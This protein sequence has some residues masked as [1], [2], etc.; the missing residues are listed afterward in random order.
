VEFSGFNE[1]NQI[2]VLLLDTEQHPYPDGLD[3]RFEHQ[4]LGG[5]T[6]G[7]LSSAELLPCTN[8]RPGCIGVI[9]QTASAVD[10]PDTQ[11]LA[12]VTLSSGTAAGP[13]TIKVFATAGG[14]ERDFTIQN[15]AIVGAKASGAQISLQCSP[16]NV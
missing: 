3:V 12:V 10:K 13:A 7:T 2:S 8:D 16:T 9:G 14:V 5:S 6:I 15:V 4:Q 11:G 1:Q